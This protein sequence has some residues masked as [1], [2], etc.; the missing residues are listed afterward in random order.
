MTIYE[1]LSTHLPERFLTEQD[2][3]L[4]AI[5]CANVAETPKELT[6]MRKRFERSFK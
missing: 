4:N 5:A 6:E 2:K 3:D 1:I